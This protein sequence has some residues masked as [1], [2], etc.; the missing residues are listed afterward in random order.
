MYNIV[1]RCRLCG[2]YFVRATDRISNDVVKYFSGLKSGSQLQQNAL[3]EV[4]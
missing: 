2:K 1:Y 3:R 4:G